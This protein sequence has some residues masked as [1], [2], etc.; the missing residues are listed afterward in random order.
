MIYP[1]FSQGLPRGFSQKAS[2]IFPEFPCPPGP[3][4]GEIGDDFELVDRGELGN[5]ERDGFLRLFELV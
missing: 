4:L 2:I 1:E 3:I 5:K